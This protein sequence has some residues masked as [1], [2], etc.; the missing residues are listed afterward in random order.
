MGRGNDLMKVLS[1]KRGRI[2]KVDNIQERGNTENVVTGMD[3]IVT[4]Q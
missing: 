3:T 4:C 1:K 2:F